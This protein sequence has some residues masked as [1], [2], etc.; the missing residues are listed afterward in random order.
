M[1]NEK[2]LEEYPKQALAQIKALLSD[3]LNYTKI[4]SLMRK[5]GYVNRLGKPITRQDI[6]YF[7]IKH[8]HRMYK[9]KRKNKKSPPGVSNTLSTSGA[10]FLRDVESIVTSNL[11]PHLK[12]RL[13]K[14]MV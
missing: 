1:S 14:A 9:K 6:S 2:Y 11:E 12:E 4:E 5:D 3:G 13:L 10:G 8:G 7:M